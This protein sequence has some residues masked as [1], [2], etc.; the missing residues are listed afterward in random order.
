MVP[1]LLS[2][3]IESIDAVVLS[4]GDLDHYNGLPEVLA[5]L[6]TQAVYV[7]P[8]LIERAERSRAPAAMKALLEKEGTLH[9]TLELPTSLGRVQLRRLWPPPEMLQDPSVSDNN[10]SEVLLLEYAGRKILLCGDI[11]EAAQ[12]QIGQ[13]YPDLN[14]DVLLLPHHGSGRNNLPG[15]IRQLQPSVRI[16]SCAPRRLVSVLPMEDNGVNYY[17]PVHGAVT[18]KI[19]ADGTLSTV[20]FLQP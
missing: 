15:W 7:N 8:G 5:S 16:V 10:K 12:R 18:I 3:G 1:F 19:K 14:L 17:T 6:P 4:H 11:E 2:Q 20:G 13:M 9:S